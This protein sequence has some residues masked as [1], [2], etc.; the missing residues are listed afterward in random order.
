[1]TALADIER[2]RVSPADSLPGSVA[3]VDD[4]AD[5][6]SRVVRAVNGIAV[7]VVPFDGTI[8]VTRTFSGGPHWEG[9]AVEVHPDQTMTLVPDW[10]FEHED[11]GTEHMEFDLDVASSWLTLETRGG[12]S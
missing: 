3:V 11:S 10:P 2:F 1:M 5:Q 7:H 8:C 6:A 9:R 4:V 12:Q